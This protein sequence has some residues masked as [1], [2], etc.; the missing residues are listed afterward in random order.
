MEITGGNRRFWDDAGGIEESALIFQNLTNLTNRPSLSSITDHRCSCSAVSCVG[1]LCEKKKKKE[2]IVEWM[3]K[4]E[5][6]SVG[7]YF[8]SS[9]RVPISFPSPSTRSEVLAGLHF[10]GQQAAA[11]FR[12]LNVLKRIC[13]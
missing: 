4:K 9:Q 6:M 3:G 13:L 8:N 5:R 11:P 7:N 2:G 10:G 1:W 12:L